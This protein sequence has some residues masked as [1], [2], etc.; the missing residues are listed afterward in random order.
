MYWLEL[1]LNWAMWPMGVLHI[2]ILLLNLQLKS[3]YILILCQVNLF[4]KPAT[5]TCTSSLT[6][7]ECIYAY[8]SR[9]LK[10]V[11]GFVKISLFFLSQFNFSNMQLKSRIWLCDLW[12]KKLLSVIYENIF[13][14]NFVN[15]IKEKS[16][17]NIIMIVLCFYFL[18]KPTLSLLL[19]SINATVLDRFHTLDQALVRFIRTATVR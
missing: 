4:Y 13:L 5:Y 11:F 10:Y 9:G 18:F 2:Y 3:V 8:N 6:R 7:S 19:I 17:T 1:V 15:I 16:Y 14:C 12:T